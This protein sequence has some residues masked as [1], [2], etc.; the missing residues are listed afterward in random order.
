MSR[1]VWIGVAILMEDGTTDTWQINAQDGPIRLQS[2]Q[3]GVTGLPGPASTWNLQD[4]LVP[5]KLIIEG[6]ARRWGPRAG[7][8]SDLI[9]PT[10]KEIG[11]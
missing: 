11:S 3:G 5:T 6:L 4:R 8:G 10:M 2:I 9:I 7:H 1:P